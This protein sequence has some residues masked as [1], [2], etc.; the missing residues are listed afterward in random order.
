M[1]LRKTFLW[2]QERKQCDIQLMKLM[3]SRL[4]IALS[5]SN[6]V[7]AE[8]EAFTVAGALV[9]SQSMCTLS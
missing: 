8:S 1:T 4:M 9:M 7:P 6:G 5:I 3:A 2:T